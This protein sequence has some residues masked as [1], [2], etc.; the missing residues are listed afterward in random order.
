MNATR[1]KPIIHLA[2]SL[3]LEGAASMCGIFNLPGDAVT[4]VRTK[5]TCEQCADVARQ[6]VLG[7]TP[8]AAA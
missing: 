3:G 5:V 4:S 6:I 8:T 2:K 1:H 7:E